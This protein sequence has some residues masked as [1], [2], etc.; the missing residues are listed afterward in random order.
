[1]RAVHLPEKPAISLLRKIQ[2][3]RLSLELDPVSNDL[4]D[5]GALC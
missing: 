4:F 5:K 3:A 2:G 1:V